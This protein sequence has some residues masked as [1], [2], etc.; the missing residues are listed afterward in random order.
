MDFYKL[1]MFYYP[2]CFVM[3]IL[4]NDSVSCEKN[5]SYCK[6]ANSGNF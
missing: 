6:R 2:N 1:G 5:V 3:L 4:E